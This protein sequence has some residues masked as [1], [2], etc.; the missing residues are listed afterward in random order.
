MTAGSTS[1]SKTMTMNMGIRDLKISAR[2]WIHPGAP[3]TGFVETHV[4][5]HMPKAVTIPRKVKKNCNGDNCDDDGDRGVFRGTRNQYAMCSLYLQ[6]GKLLGV[7]PRNGKDSMFEEIYRHWSLSR[8]RNSLYGGGLIRTLDD[9]VDGDRLIFHCGSFHK[10]SGLAADFLQRLPSDY[11]GLVKVSLISPL[12]NCDHNA[13][14]GSSENMISSNKLPKVASAPGKQIATA[15]RR[16]IVAPVVHGPKH[17]NEVIEISSDDES[18]AS[19]VDDVTDEWR[20]KR[21][22]ERRKMRENAEEID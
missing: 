6:I 2:L 18:E 20:A 10:S 3:V 7:R 4:H 17:S 16:P 21:E 22:E 19:S 1:N 5:I 13:S 14:A 9:L 8:N 12:R 15:D 11:K